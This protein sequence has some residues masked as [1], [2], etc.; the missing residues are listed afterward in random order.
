MTLPASGPISLSQVNVE[1]LR[2]A[3][4]SINL[5]DSAV[6]TLAQVGGS[7]TQISMSSLLGK[8]IDFAF[9]F[10]GG[11][12]LNLRDVAISYGWNQVARL[13]ASNVGLITSTTNGQYALTIAGSFPNGVTF[14]NYSKIVGKGG[15]GGSGAG[16]DGGSSGSAGGGGNPAVIASVAVT[17]YNGTG[18]IAGGGGGG[19]G[20]QSGVYQISYP[21]YPPYERR[22]GA[23]GGGGGGGGGN[24]IGSGGGTGGGGSNI[25][26]RSLDGALYDIGLWGDIPNPNSYIYSADGGANGGTFDAGGAGGG[27]GGGGRGC[28]YFYRRVTAAS[29]GSP[30]YSTDYGA[31][32]GNGGDGGYIG[33]S[34]GDGGGYQKGNIS[35][36]SAAGGG[37]AAGV[38]VQGDS[39]VSWASLGTINGGRVG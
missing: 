22:F 33:S 16:P 21:D 4:A 26:G 5:N 12:Q 6:R 1:L 29:K 3:T 14:I 15:D 13:T 39:N 35:L 11:N 27:G 9:T 24:G 38:A 34:G 28:S 18:Q 10:Y 19:G 31:V 2:S 37:G 7:G 23:A 25:D 17:I 36:G 8:S 30:E 20:G 32:G